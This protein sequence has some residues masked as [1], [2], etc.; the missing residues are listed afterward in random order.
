MYILCTHNFLVLES[1]G[2][3][4]YVFLLFVV[5]WKYCG[6]RGAENGISVRPLDAMVRGR[7][8]EH[9]VGG[10]TA[11]EGSAFKGRESIGRCYRQIL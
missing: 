11:E 8:Y 2:R 3:L 9:N 6:R 1:P 5:R 7:Y 10:D 4:C